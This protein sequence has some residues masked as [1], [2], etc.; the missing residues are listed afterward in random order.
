MIDFEEFLED[1]HS[2]GPVPG[3][4]DV[5]ISY[6]HRDQLR[7]HALMRKIEALGFSAFADLDFPNLADT[8][9]VDPAKIATIRRVLARATCL[10]VA[11]S[12]RDEAGTKD[13]LG[14]WMPWELGYFDGSISRRIGV[15]LLD[16]APEDFD[17]ATAF[18]GNEYLRLYQTLVDRCPGNVPMRPDGMPS[19][20]ALESFL[21]RYAPR[22]RRVDNTDAAFVWLERIWSEALANPANLALGIAQWQVA[23]AAAWW[24]DLGL[25]PAARAGEDLAKALDQARVTW[26]RQWRWHWVD[27]WLAAME[28][29]REAAILE[30]DPYKAMM[31]AGDNV[32]QALMAVRPM[33]DP[34]G[35][36]LRFPVAAGT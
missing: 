30:A 16:G 23:H 3:T 25:E 7:A 5:F 28:G 19:Q 32:R 1:R 12:S 22:E 13:S 17:P 36:G 21:G 24:R 8:S 29:A 6:R 18:V 31:L 4:F 35:L 26:A 20:M 9:E 33:F 15:Y 11:C 34:W 2:P 27:H 10:I 14:V